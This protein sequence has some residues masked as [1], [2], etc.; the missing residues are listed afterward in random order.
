MFEY[1]PRECLYHLFPLSISQA[2]HSAQHIMSISWWQGGSKREREGDHK[3]E[4]N[5]TIGLSPQIKQPSLQ[6]IQ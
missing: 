6:E 1:F 4:A 3:R 5:S 2:W